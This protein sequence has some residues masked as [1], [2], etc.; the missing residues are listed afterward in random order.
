M[1]YMSKRK[2]ALERFRNN[3]RNVRFKELMDLLIYLGFEK[4][5]DSSSHTVFTY[6]S[7]P[8]ILTIPYRKPFLKPCYVMQAIQAIDELGLM[9]DED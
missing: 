3:P 7:Q 6:P 4:R 5:H 8:T 1:A 9:D 2:K